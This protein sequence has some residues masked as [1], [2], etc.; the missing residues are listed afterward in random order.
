M[1]RRKQETIRQELQPYGD[2]FRTSTWYA[3]SPELSAIGFAIIITRNQKSRIVTIQ[4]RII[5]RE[6]ERERDKR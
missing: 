6:R 1:R 4:Q 2:S 3:K 5:E